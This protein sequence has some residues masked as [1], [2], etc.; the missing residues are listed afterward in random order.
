MMYCPVIT[1]IT[2][3]Y[4]EIKAVPHKNTYLW[5]RW[6][7]LLYQR[8][9]PTC[10]VTADHKQ[11]L[12]SKLVVYCK[13]QKLMIH[14]KF[15][16]AYTMSVDSIIYYHPI[17]CSINGYHVLLLISFI[18]QCI[19]YSVGLC[20]WPFFWCVYYSFGNITNQVNQH[21]THTCSSH[22]TKL[23]P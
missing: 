23:M 12:L 19:C 10:R 4:M 22:T 16:L 21:C 7:C 11:Q 6:I 18:V 3:K 20:I 17:W 2:S 5:W 8:R 9:K 13:R 14:W 1:I 15:A